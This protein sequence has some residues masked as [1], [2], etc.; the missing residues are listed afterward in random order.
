MAISRPN[1]VK[2]YFLNTSSCLMDVFPHI[3][4]FSRNLTLARFSSWRNVEIA[5]V[6][7]GQSVA[8]CK[9]HTFLFQ[10]KLGWS[11]SR[12]LFNHMQKSV[13]SIS[14]K[15]KKSGTNWRQWEA[16][17]LMWHHCDIMPWCP[18]VARSWIK[19]FK[20]WGLNKYGR[21]ISDDIFNVFSWTKISLF[22]LTAICS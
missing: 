6:S 9:I 12:D 16:M 8:H 19:Q 7:T 22:K 18:I 15:R 14:T 10:I 5:I 13:A 3:K 21:Q 2:S 1:W 11:I 20:H 4:P 17:T